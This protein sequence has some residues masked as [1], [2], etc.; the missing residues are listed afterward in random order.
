[1]MEYNK[2]GAYH[3]N[4]HNYMA[5][6]THQP[7]FIMVKWYSGNVVTLYRA[8]A[9]RLDKGQH[10]ASAT[11]QHTTPGPNMDVGAGAGAGSCLTNF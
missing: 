6:T 2:Y 3:C 1:M 5:I 8:K 4:N 10:R 7:H 9:P 11:S